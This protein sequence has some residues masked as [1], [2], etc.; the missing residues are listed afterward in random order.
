[1]KLHKEKYVAFLRGINVGGHHKVPMADLKKVLK[2]LGFENC[3]TLLN[4]GNIIFEA[5]EQPIKSL[6]QKLSSK[7]ESHFGFAIPTITRTYNEINRTFVEA[8]F[9]NIE[10][11]KD[12]RLYISFLKEDKKIELEL[13]W[14]SQ[15]GSFKVLQNSNG[16]IIS[17]LDLSI[18]KTPKAMEVLEKHYGKDITTRNW[19]TIVRIVNKIATT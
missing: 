3:I 9:K 16:N 8:P 5:D 7:L 14:I 15:D 10:V 1:M 17:I 2:N 18:N 4:S 19:N 12:I 11:T 13:P 6:E